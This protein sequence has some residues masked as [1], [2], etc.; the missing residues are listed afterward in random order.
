M[1]VVLLVTNIAAKKCLT[2]A[3]KSVR[4]AISYVFLLPQLYPAAIIIGYCHNLGCMVIG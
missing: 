3:S 4:V 2:I 1:C